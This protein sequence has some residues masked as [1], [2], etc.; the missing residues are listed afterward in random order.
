MML[1]NMSVWES[2]ETLAAFTYSTAHRDVM[3]RRRRWFERLADAFLVLWWIRAGTLPTMSDAKASLERL[4]RNGPSRE[5]FTFRSPFPAP[6]AIAGTDRV[7]NEWS[8]P[9]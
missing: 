9:T 2:I 1:V 3:R 5:A 6:T 4:R 8:C 7:A